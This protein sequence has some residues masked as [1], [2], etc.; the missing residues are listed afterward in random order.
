LPILEQIAGSL[1]YAHEQGI[2]H[3][4]VKPGNIIVK[5][6]KTGLKAYL[7]DF[8]LVKAMEGTLAETMTIQATNLG[9]PEYMSPEQADPNHQHVVGPAA[10]R[11]ALGVLVYRL[12]T[13]QVPFSGS[14][15]MAT[16]YG[17]VHLLP[18]DPR[19][20]RPD[21]PEG[22]EHILLKMLAKSPDER[23][24]N[25]AAFVA[26]LAEPPRKQEIWINPIT[27][28]EMV[29]IPA[30][31]F[32]FGEGKVEQ[33]LPEFWID[34]VPVTNAQY[35]RFVTEKTS[36]IPRHWGGKKEPPPELA[37]H[38]VVNVSWEDAEAYT[39]WA[40]G[41]LPTEV[42]WEKAARGTDGRQYPWGDKWQ[43]DRCNT[44]AA[45]IG[46]T[47]PVDQFSPAGDS[48]Y[49]CLD[50]SGNVWE[51]TGTKEGKYYILK[52]GAY[53]VSRDRASTTAR[54]AA[55]NVSTHSS[56]LGYGGL[57]AVVVV[58]SSDRVVQ[59][60][61]SNNVDKE[62]N[63]SM[64][65]SMVQPV[66]QGASFDMWVNPKT[67]REMVRVPA[68]PFLFGEKKAR[69]ELPEF[70][71]DKT[72]V[73]NAEYARFVAERRYRTPSH[74]D[75]KKEPLRELA[76]HPVVYVS[77][78]EANAFAEWAG[79]SLPSEE[80]WEKAARGTDGRQYPWGDEWRDSRCNTKEA[81][82][83]KT[84][85]V[86]HFSPAGDSPYGCVDMS[87]NVWEWT[88][89]KYFVKGGSWA[90]SKGPARAAARSGPDVYFRLDDDGFRVVVAV[91][92]SASDL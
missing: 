13:G 30:G 67:G 49:G 11:Y 76:D 16:L 78:Q 33:E 35:A 45:G 58:P 40:G 46:K 27:G 48:P 70:W 88:S 6:D 63:Q 83:G 80:Q 14:N 5:E 54:A 57:R 38:P 32:L 42:Q 84:T 87:G 17:H 72:P 91:P 18:P 73:T 43:D 47:T 22:V 81:G 66:L 65:Q 1:D 52:G 29:L 64:K 51:W 12:L 10:D 68:G 24:D 4:D 19:Q 25:C 92:S 23:F 9:S 15:W 39:K 37:D 21:L 2:V 7:T 89:E 55:L 59:I 90:T 61:T 74:W 50:M 85:S 82:I 31:S 26:A 34:K 44:K 36:E 53:Y 71:I 60:P 75:G 20:I 3:R 77:W 86:G 69:R 28:K 8:G 41:S 62:K 56:R 79:G